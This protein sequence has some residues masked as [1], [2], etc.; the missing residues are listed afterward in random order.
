MPTLNAL[1]PVL[2]INAVVNFVNA[3]DNGGA[4]IAPE[5][6]YS[7]QLL[8]TIRIDADQFVYFRLA[9]T[10]PIQ[11]KADKLLLRRWSSLQAH[12]VP[13][14]EGIP[15]KSD[16]GSVEKYELQA[17][18][19]GRYMEFSDR[20]NFKVVDPVIAHYSKEYSIV[21]METLDM[22]A[23]DTLFTVAQKYYAGAAVTS[24]D[25]VTFALSPPTMLDLRKIVL[26]MKKALI[27][28]RSNGKFHV[29]G[30]ADFYFDMIAD[31]TVEKYMTYNQ[32]TKNMYDGGV[33]PIVPMFDLEFYES[34]VVPQN[35]EYY[36]SSGYKRLKQYT[37]TIASPTITAGNDLIETN[38]AHYASVDGYIAD[39][40][41]GED[42]S[43]VP[44]QDTWTL[45]TDTFEFKVEHT[46]VLGKDALTRTGLAGEDSAKMYV[47]PLGSSGV[48]D[49]I[50]QRQSIGFKINSIGF[51][52]TRPEAVY[53]YVNVPSQL[54]I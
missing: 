45:P 38:S 19:Y 15:P 36:D 40:R 41:T 14:A 44:D 50:D 11:Q 28:P 35:G 23:R 13:L 10:S 24:M 47:K 48:L 2:D 9:D 54:N 37:G 29:I 25:E 34:L 18:A 21:A 8:E 17:F 26:A 30:S 42:A 31:A 3:Q 20:V 32:T 46:L 22:L 51:G 7:L 39:A 43:Y 27:K 33:A 6:F 4:P 1:N 52:S 12:I 16:K 49:P 5:T 53:D